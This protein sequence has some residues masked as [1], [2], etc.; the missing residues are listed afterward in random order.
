MLEM[1]NRDDADH[2]TKAATVLAPHIGQPEDYVSALDAIEMS[3]CE[4]DMLRAH[5]KSPGPQD[6]RFETGRNGW[7]FRVSDRQ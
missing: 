4:R 1:I 5:A 6:Y 3:S 2:G 7:A